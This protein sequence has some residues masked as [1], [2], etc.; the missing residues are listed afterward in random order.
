MGAT[1][2]PDR[3]ICFCFGHS[4]SSIRAEIARSGRTTVVEDVRAKIK[5]GLCSCE[6]LNPKKTCCLG[7]LMSAVSAA[8]SSFHPGDT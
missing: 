8:Y 5:A 1:P 4:V 3:M 6:S 7:D 2:E